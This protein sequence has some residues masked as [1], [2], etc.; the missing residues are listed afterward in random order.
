MAGQ[1]GKPSHSLLTPVGSADSTSRVQR[2]YSAAYYIRFRVYY[3]WP[4]VQTNQTKSNR[5]QTNKQAIKSNKQSNTFQN[6][7]SADPTGVN[8]LWD[9]IW[10]PPLSPH[11]G[12]QVVPECP[13][14]SPRGV[15]P[16]VKWFRLPF[17]RCFHTLMVCLILTI[18]RILKNR[19]KWH[20]QSTLDRPRFVFGSKSSTFGILLAYICL[21][22][23]KWR[24]CVISEEYN[25]KHGSEPSK[26]FDFR[27]DFS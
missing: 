17:E 24:K 23:R 4:V 2:A 12:I 6:H 1:R 13:R 10:F 7:K 3:I 21:F 11:P 18:F 26:A 8:R 27:I 25:A 5:N 16:P 22:F 20:N 9:V 14:G 15:P 19:P